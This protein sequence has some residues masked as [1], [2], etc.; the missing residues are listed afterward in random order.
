MQLNDKTRNLLNKDQ[1]AQR[2][3]FSI[4]TIDYKM[5]S[6]ELPFVKFRG[7]V[8]FLPEDVDRWISSHRVGGVKSKI[9]KGGAGP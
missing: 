9:R 7:A 5:A 2:T 6:G 1:V 4:R 8:R 3:Q